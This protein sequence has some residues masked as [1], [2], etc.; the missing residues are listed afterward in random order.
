M[1]FISDFS[2]VNKYITLKPYPRPKIA[3]VFQKLE[4]IKYTSQPDLSMNVFT[5]CLHADSQKIYII[6]IV[7][8]KYQELVP[9]E[10]Y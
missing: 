6:I 3:D 7:W 1:R 9:S 5:V 2:Y 4:C 8:V 10:L